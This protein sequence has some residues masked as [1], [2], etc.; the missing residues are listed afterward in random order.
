MIRKIKQ[1]LL[2]DLVKVSGLTAASTFTKLLSTFISA[3]ILAIVTGPDGV[4]L[5]GQLNNGGMIMYT[6]ASAAINVGVTKYIAQYHYD[7]SKQQTIINT[8]FKVT[9]IC[10]F[11]VTLLVFFFSAQI[12][13]YL[14]KAYTYTSIIRLFPFL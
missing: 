8:S 13:Y 14:F 1:L 10:S 7:K 11:V 4:A 12:G 6:L 3:K 2:T 9:L 5:L